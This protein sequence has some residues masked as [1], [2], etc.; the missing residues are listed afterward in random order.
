MRKKLDGLVGVITGAGSGIG[1]A[2]ARDLGGSGMRLVLVG[3]RQNLLDECAAE[4]RAR[5][6]DAV[7]ISADV[8]NF[9]EV[10]GAVGLALDRWG[11]V[12]VLVPNA[13]VADFGPIARADPKLMRD[14]VETNLIGVMFAVR[15]ALPCMEERRSGHIVIVS[16]ASGRVTYV[17]EPAYVAS[18]HGTVAF[19]D[20][21]RQEVAPT[22][23]RV[24]LIEPG[25][26]E[27][28]LIHVYPEANDLVPGVIALDPDDIASAVRYVLE[29]PDNVNV[30]EVL[31]RPTG[32]LL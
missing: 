26:V 31:L 32:Q 28:P 9:E 30:F 7:G 25:L 16:S 23:I 5:G 14:V 3:R 6:G 4:V 27:T 20:C 1:A 17:G 22:G 19:A 18:K 13:A 2:I 8:R 21:L 29:Q 11:K 15:A 24:S 12:D 10:E